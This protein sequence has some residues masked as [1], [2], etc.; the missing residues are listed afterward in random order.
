MSTSLWIDGMVACESAG[1]HRGEQVELLA[2]RRHHPGGVAA[3]IGGVPDRAHRSSRR[4]RAG[5]A[6]SPRAAYCRA[7]RARACRSAAPASRSRGASRDGRGL[8]HLDAF[9]NDFEADVVAEQ[10]SDLQ[11]RFPRGTRSYSLLELMML[12]SG[13]SRRQGP[14]SLP[15]A[16]LCAS[17]TED[18]C[19]TTMPPFFESLP[20]S[21]ALST[22]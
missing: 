13:M 1:P 12:A 2:H 17:S 11:C 10:N 18:C 9:R 20:A 4:A 5:P 8:H 6:R 3:R 21:P 22:P 15:S 16:R 14:P 7:A 19:G